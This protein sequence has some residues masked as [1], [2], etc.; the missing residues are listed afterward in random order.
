MNKPNIECFL[1]D[2]FLVFRF[3]INTKQSYY[4]LY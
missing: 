3:I 4:C 1:G 2:K